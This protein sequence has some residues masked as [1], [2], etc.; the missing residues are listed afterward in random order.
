V[1][2]SCDFADG[3]HARAALVAALVGA[4]EGAALVSLAGVEADAAG[5]AAGVDAAP[6]PDGIA[7]H[8]GVANEREMKRAR[9]NREYEAVARGTM[10]VGSGF[11]MN[12]SVAQ[13]PRKTPFLRATGGLANV[14][15]DYPGYPVMSPISR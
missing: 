12:A 5:T 11:E 9:M 8:S 1:K 2:G 7:K 4:V 13:R 3:K 6:H 14:R 10:S 15:S